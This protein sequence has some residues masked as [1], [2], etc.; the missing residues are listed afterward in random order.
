MGCKRR[1]NQRTAPPDLPPTPAANPLPVQGISGG[2]YYWGYA[3]GVVATKVSGWGEVVL[4]EWTQP[5]DCADVSYFF[6]LMQDTE[7]RL[8]FRPRFGAFDAAFDAFYV[9][10]YFHRE[11]HAWPAAF[12]AVPFATRGA[13]QK[14]IRCPGLTTLRR[15]VGYAA[16]AALYLA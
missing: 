9:Y 1:R 7:R 4:A 6:P 10:E 16:Q 5:F 15:R 11:G 3:S 8:G 13:R 12:A 14:G 2:E